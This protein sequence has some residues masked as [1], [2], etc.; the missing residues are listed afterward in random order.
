MIYSRLENVESHLL[1]RL[2]P[3]RLGSSPPVG[4]HRRRRRTRRR[5]RECRSPAG[6]W[7]ALRSLSR[8]SPQSGTRSTGPTT[9]YRARRVRSGLPWQARS[10]S[11]SGQRSWN[12]RRWPSPNAPP[13]RW[14]T[15]LRRS[16]DPA[17]GVLTAHRGPSGPRG[18]VRLRRH[19]RRRGRLRRCIRLA[20]CSSSIQGLLSARNPSRRY[21]PGG[22]KRPTAH[23]SPTTPLPTH[24]RALAHSSSGLCC[25][26]A[27]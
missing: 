12:P 22:P 26:L 8:H 11:H 16:T 15:F 27:P 1:L 5:S 20:L 14:M 6:F 24:W 23:G 13:R 4:P 21:C 2:S 3:G 7:Y 25:P 10:P 19:P 18:P 9:V 17:P